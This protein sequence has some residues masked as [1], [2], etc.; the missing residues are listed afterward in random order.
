MTIAEALA[1]F[2]CPSSEPTLAR[3]NLV[4]V[5]DGAFSARPHRIKESTYIDYPNGGEAIFLESL[6]ALKAGGGARA[7]A[8]LCKTADSLRVPIILVPTG[9]ATELRPTPLS[10]EELTSYYHRFGFKPLKAIR[11]GKWLTSIMV[12]PC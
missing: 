6:Q 7:L 11:P 8:S 2:G 1:N 5:G 9:Y 3:R 4:V 10:V 12:R